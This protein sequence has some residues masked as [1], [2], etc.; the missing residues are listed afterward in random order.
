[1]YRSAEGRSQLCLLAL[2]WLAG[3][4][5]ERSS[6]ASGWRMGLYGVA[7]GVALASICLMVPV[8]LLLMELL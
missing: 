7:L 5:A 1:M 3:A 4:A 6:K 8:F 2:R